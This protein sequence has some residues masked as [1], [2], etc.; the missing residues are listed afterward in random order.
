MNKKTAII[1]I[2]TA[3]VVIMFADKIN[4]LPLVNKIP[5]F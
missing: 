2:A 4:G 1:V 5:R 3:I